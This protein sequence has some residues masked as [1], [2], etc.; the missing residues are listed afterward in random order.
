MIEYAAFS[1]ALGFVITAAMLAQ[2]F[3][4]GGDG[5]DSWWQPFCLTLAFAF[6]WPCLAIVCLVDGYR[7]LK[8]RL[9]R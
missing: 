7:W 2:N 6:T 8:E 4:E 5:P 3:A 9:T 1:L